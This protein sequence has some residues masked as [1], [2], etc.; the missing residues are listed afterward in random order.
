MKETHVDIY[1]DDLIEEKQE[2][3]YEILG[4]DY[5]YENEP[6]ISIDYTVYERGEYEEAS[7]FKSEN[8]LNDIFRP[9]H[10]RGWRK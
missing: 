3:I 6:I 5:D 10:R 8:T 2:E 4:D 1:L 9:G 7:K